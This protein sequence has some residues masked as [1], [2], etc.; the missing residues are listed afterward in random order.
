MV[1]LMAC[2]MARRIIHEIA[3]R[4]VRRMVHRMVCRMARRMVCRMA[5]QGVCWLV[6]LRARRMARRIIH[7]IAR[8]MVRRMARR[9]VRQTI[10]EMDRS[11]VCVHNNGLSSLLTI[12]QPEMRLGLLQW[13][14]RLRAGVESVKKMEDLDYP[15]ESYN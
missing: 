10:F 8:R 7:E 2:R 14:H 1:C 12:W 5:R 11:R 9:M 6:R 3:R 13:Q 4:M 15:L